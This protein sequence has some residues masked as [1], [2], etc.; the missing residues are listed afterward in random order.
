MR[1]S[2]M[3]F[4]WEQRCNGLRERESRRRDSF[5]WRDRLHLGR[6]FSTKPCASCSVR[7]VT[8]ELPLNDERRAP[9]RVGS[10]AWYKAEWKRFRELAAQHEGLTQP[11]FAAIALGVHRSRIY[12]LM[13][14]GH[15]PS[16]EIMGKRFVS[17]KEI[18]RFAKLERTSGTR[19]ATA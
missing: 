2:A 3:I 15:V 18:E 10:R 11:P 6:I 12:Q 7:T 8:D 9:G 1:H 4:P 13:D 5:G 19:Y 17:C 14:A 16:F